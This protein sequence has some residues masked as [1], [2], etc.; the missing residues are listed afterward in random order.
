V[1]VFYGA[2]WADGVG[3]CLPSILVDVKYAYFF[4]GALPGGCR[5]SA[6]VYFLC[7][8]HLNASEHT[9]K[10]CECRFVRE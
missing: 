9:R 3:R 7:A 1:R 8:L 5:A 10:V 2:R 4:G 6:L